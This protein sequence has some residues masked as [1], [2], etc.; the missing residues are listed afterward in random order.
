MSFENI[1]EELYEILFCMDK[2][3]VMKIP[4]SYLNQ[5]IKN[6]NKNFK[7][8]ID[9]NDLFNENNISKEA[10]DLLCWFDYNYWADSKRKQKINDLRKKFL[11]EEE[12]KKRK[13]YNPCNIFNNKKTSV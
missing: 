8:K 11:I 6:R 7:T 10:M 3:T 4:E 12:E 5:I 2:A 13:K 9:K 1:C